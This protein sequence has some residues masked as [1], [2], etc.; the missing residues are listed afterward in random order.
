MNQYKI[1]FTAVPWKTPADGVREKT[2]ERNDKRL[3]LIEFSKGFVEK[4]WCLSSHIGYVLDGKL[5]I[6]F[7]GTSVSYNSGDAIFIPEGEKHKHK[8][9]IVADTVTVFAVDNK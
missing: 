4:D 8:A 2:V 7:N 6:N 3:R 5:D 1:D 9:H